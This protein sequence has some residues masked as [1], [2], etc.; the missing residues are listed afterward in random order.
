MLEEE[1]GMCALAE[2]HIGPVF[3]ELLRSAAMM[4]TCP[5]P[6][7]SIIDVL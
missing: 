1:R 5:I 2:K 3:N 7:V 4:P 6:K